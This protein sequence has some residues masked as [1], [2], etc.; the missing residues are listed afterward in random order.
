MKFLF[1]T[2]GFFALVFLLI[3][4]SFWVNVEEPNHEFEPETSG[5]FL[6]IPPEIPGPVSTI[7]SPGLLEKAFCYLESKRIRKAC[8]YLE[9][10]D[11]AVVL[12][13]PAH[14]GY[15]N[16]GQVFDLFDYINE[17]WRYTPDPTGGEYFSKASA[18]LSH[19]HGDCDDQAIL[20][21]SCLLAIG[22]YPHLVFAT[23][24]TSGH[25]YCEVNLGRMDLHEIGSYI[26]K[27]YRLSNIYQIHYRTDK[28]GNIYL[29]L[30]FGAYPG[31]PYYDATEEWSYDFFTGRC[32][33]S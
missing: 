20:M 4:H 30:D 15:L 6:P 26:Q 1:H 29:N 10:R 5:T 25:A 31:A 28:T 7:E 32:L 16:L 11:D 2:A 3:T 24:E 33:T 18:S 22:G 8:D 9:I 13:H 27:R 14:D 23:N 12:I 19:L 21:A 17:N